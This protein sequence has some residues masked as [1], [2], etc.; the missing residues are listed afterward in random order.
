MTL[1]TILLRHLCF[2][3][4]D[5]PQ[6]LLVF[7]HGLNV[8][9]GASETGKSFVLETIDFMLG[10]RG[11]LRDIP[12]RVGYERIF[13]G[14]ETAENGLFT[15]VR[16]TNGGQFQLY[17]GLHQSLP[18]EIEA[19]VLSSRHSAENDNNLSSFLLH[20]IGLN[21]KR[22]R[23]NAR[24]DTRSLSFRDLCRLCLVNEG[25]IQKQGSPIES[26]QAIQKTPE[27][28]TF[29][30]LLTGVDDSA[31]VSASGD[32]ALSQSRAAK[33]EFIDELIAS[34]QDKIA[35]SEDD[36]QELTEQ[37][38][39]LEA[40]IA[41]EQQ[42]L[43]VSEQQYQALIGSRNDLRQRL[44]NGLERRGEIDELMARFSLLD[45]HYQSDLARLGGICEAGSL[46]AALSA[47]AC[48]LCGADPDHQHRDGG[49]DGN[50]EAIVAAADA[51]SAKIIRLR[52]ELEETVRQLGIE[53][54]S[55]D[56][57]I[58]KMHD[59]LSKLQEDIQALGPGLMD[60]RT[61]YTE[62][63]EKR[64]SLRASLSVCDQLADLQARREELEKVPGG[65]GSHQ[66]GNIDLSST[67]LDQF[68]RQVEQLLRAW[69]FPEAERV[70]FE[71]ADRDLIISG[72][73]RSS[74]GKG[75]RAITHAAFI[76]GLL[77]FCRAQSKPHPGFVILDSPLLAYR[78]PEG[79]EDDLTGTDV[80]DKF[81]QY[82]AALTDSQVII[83]E[84]IDPP[85]AITSRPTST[86][87]SKNPH[88]GRYGFFP[89]PDA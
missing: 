51:E 16:A 12:E 80:Q 82:L 70:Y 19:T 77:E 87:F 21:G 27:Y 40:S 20:K 48:P 78:E 83:I 44:Q 18:V 4:P 57:L 23:T 73:R 47:G 45:E 34:Y 55:F 29:K 7:D 38:K 13:L 6:A 64:A 81:Y 60:L 65:D 37:L 5:K 58:P 15:L 3:G 59:D 30:L 14:V 67:T 63:V 76:V 61:T 22:V 9:Y 17:E 11:P 39:K 66:Q 89:I 46:V 85:Q 71:Q 50:L 62:L 35:D 33:I 69:N 56:R 2:T 84:N 54:R 49:C 28:A 8:L 24:G 10:G 52:R 42:A 32:V 79:V 31:L 1:P 53:A 68:A 36:P 88:Y 74:R 25:E 41:R 72:K 26:G 75:M 43:R 86:F